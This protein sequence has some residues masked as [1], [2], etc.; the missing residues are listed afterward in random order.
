MGKFQT[1]IVRDGFCF[2]LIICI[3]DHR[4]GYEWCNMAMYASSLRWQAEVIR[5]LL[6]FYTILQSCRLS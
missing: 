6:L 1:E 4:V 3:C 5:L 2:L